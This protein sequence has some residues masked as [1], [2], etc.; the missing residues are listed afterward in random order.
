MTDI[1]D[2]DIVEGLRQFDKQ[3]TLDYFYGY[4]REAYDILKHK[5]SLW[6]K[7][8]MDFYSLAHEYY[9]KLALQQFAPLEARPAGVA[10][11]NWMFG[12]FRFVV[13]DALKAFNR[14]Y[15][16]AVSGEPEEALAQL[17]TMPKDDLLGMVAAEVEKSYNDE[18]MTTIARMLIVE[19]YSQKEVAQQLGITPSAVNQRYKKMMDEVMI[20]YVYANYAYGLPPITREC[21]MAET[22]L[23]EED[24]ALYSALY[25]RMGCR[26]P[27]VVEHLAENEVYVFVTDSEGR[28]FL[29]SA[30]RAL[31]W[32]AEVGCCSGAK[33]KT[34]AMPLLGSGLAKAE[35]H[36]RDFAVYAIQHPEQ[37]FVA[38]ELDAE[39]LGYADEEMAQLFEWLS[40]VKNIVL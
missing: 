24:S 10:L 3:T 29:P 33:G 31:R 5:Y 35:Q 40:G 23:C 36:F 6:Q 22:L 4:C 8:G 21:R 27:A 16:R 11:K 18:A 17:R 26:L 15:E 30:Q 13:L 34:Y 9:I 7:D 14:E 28:H 38:T 39:L 37:T 20:P 32:G 2:S 25:G 12:G 19:G 1:T